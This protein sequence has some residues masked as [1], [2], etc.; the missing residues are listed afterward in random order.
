MQTTKVRRF[1]LWVTLVSA[2]FP[3]AFVAGCK[4]TDEAPAPM[5]AGGETGATGDLG[6]AGTTGATP[7]VAT[8]AAGGA[9]A[10]PIPTINLTAGA[11]GMPQIIV[12]QGPPGTPTTF[13]L[14]QGSVTVVPGTSSSP[15]TI[16][17]PPGLT[18]P[19]SIPLPG[20]TAPPATTVK[21]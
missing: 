8:M 10:Y 2:A 18:I 6:G 11:G 1:A 5:G 4:K 19:T 3:A 16:Q 20:F 15:P 7:G 12:Q 13:V 21:K 17:L 14:P 9:A